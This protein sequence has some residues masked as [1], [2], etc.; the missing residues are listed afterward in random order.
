MKRTA[1]RLG[2]F[3]LCLLGAVLADAVIVPT[4]LNGRAG[5]HFALGFVV[6]MG[7]RRGPLL[8]L[9]VGW[10]AALA[11]GSL[12]LEPLGLTMLIFGLTGLFAGLFRKASDLR[13]P[14]IDAAVILGLLFAGELSVGALAWMVYDTPLRVGLVAV[15]VTTIAASVA[16]TIWQPKERAEAG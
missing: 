10:A 8:G 1:Q 3:L 15:A 7:L 5:A 4:L 12:S 14:L 13:I 2:I 6:L 9:F 11:R 16:A